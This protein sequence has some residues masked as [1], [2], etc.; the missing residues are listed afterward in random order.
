MT[1]SVQPVA[2]DSGA[3]QHANAIYALG[4]SAGKSAR[5]QRQADETAPDS[6]AL[7]D[8]SACGPCRPRS[9]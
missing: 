9:T 2:G 5:L 6:A 4:R 7:L 1:E 3:S 8:R